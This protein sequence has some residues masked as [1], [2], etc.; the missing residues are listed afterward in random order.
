M[1]SYPVIN[2]RNCEYVMWEG[3]LL[4]EYSPPQKG[5]RSN[6]PQEDV[7]EQLMVLDGGLE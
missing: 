2:G 6:Q 3:V 1:R 4:R 5:V 7:A